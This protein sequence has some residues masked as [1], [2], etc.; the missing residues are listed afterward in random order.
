PQG[1]GLPARLRLRR[2]LPRQPRRSAVNPLWNHYRCADDQWIALS[3]LQPDRYWAQFCAALEI[4]EAAS[5]PRFRTMLDRMMNCTDCIALLD[6][7]FARRPRAEWLRR[8][9]QGG[10][11]LLSIINSV[12]ALPDHPQTPAD[13]SHT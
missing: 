8:L 7:V 12:A 5:D 10:D 11:S 1:P 4:P 9:A 6:E 2:A 3:M 13:C